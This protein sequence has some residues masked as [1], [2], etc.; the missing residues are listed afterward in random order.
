MS[1]R[2]FSY[3]KLRKQTHE[4]LSKIITE[5]DWLALPRRAPHL[6]YGAFFKGGL[7]ICF[8]YFVIVARILA[9]GGWLDRRDLLR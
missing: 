2:I 4:F 5:G 1:L 3:C 6:A 9:A 8:Y 7:G